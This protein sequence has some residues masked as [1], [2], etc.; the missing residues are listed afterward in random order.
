MKARGTAEIPH[1]AAP[2]SAGEDSDDE[3]SRGGSRLSLD[4]MVPPGRR[5]LNKDSSSLSRAIPASPP[6]PSVP[7]RTST[8]SPPPELPPTGH[9]RPPQK[10]VSRPPPPVPISSPPETS[11]V[12][13]RPP[14]PP[15]PGQPPSRK[16]TSDSRTAPHPSKHQVDNDSEEEVT[17]YDG[18]YD[19][20]IASGAKHKD[21]LK[22][23]D[24][25]SSFD[26]G[27]ITDEATNKSPT[28]PPAR[29]PPPLP[30]SVAPRAIPPAPPGQPPKPNRKSSDMPRAAPPPI[31][32]S[33]ESI[34]NEDYDPFRYTRGVPPP[35]P[36]N[37]RPPIIQSPSNELEEDDM[38]GASPVSS[39]PMPPAPAI[40]RTVPPPAPP[41]ERSVP[42]PPPPPS[43][44]SQPLPGGTN[45]PRKSLD[46]NRSKSTGR[47][48]MEQPRA[49][50]DTGFIASDIDLA[51]KSFWWTQQNLPPQTLQS[52]RDVIFEMDTSPPTQEGSKTIITK[53]I[54]VLYLDYSHT[55]ITASFDQSNPSDVSLEQK[56]QRPPPPPRQD[57]LEN[58]SLHL[59][60]RISEAVTA[61]QNTVVGDGS[62]H[63]LVLE[64]L[65]P[66]ASEA[67][68]P[69][70]NRTYGALVYA[71]LANASTQQYD[72]I[73]AGD[74][75]TFRNAKFQG[76]RGTM[77]QK[78]S[79]EAG[80]PDH[81]GIVLD[82]DGTKKK[83]RAW[84][85]GR[86]NKKVKLE[87]F[88]LGDL[89]SGECRVWRIMGRE[90]VGWDAK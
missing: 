67:L 63:A 74:I 40:E 11:P 82:W 28:S 24:G 83:I 56:H 58:A 38:Y 75:V 22:A 4:Q 90:W 36:P 57:Q 39:P 64:L 31:P 88:K 52:R 2:L 68:M 1:A 65:R 85:Q 47:R 54:Y 66:L 6:V 27:T 3:L 16:S 33:R 41:S 30:P 69:I 55:T 89:R 14:P 80:K 37:T 73:R 26:E 48:S 62:P 77:H 49:S 18:D 44:S 43:Q 15:P 29:G 78:Y 53:D 17:E 7:L 76:H 13:S 72:E 42:L 21:A 50:L 61:A 60:A 87:S 25:D 20:D 45:L 59:G 70:A 35:P 81:V 84:E 8:E 10:R 12:Q 51:E 19:T 34:D 71:N 23:H 79:A 86:E 46:V 9:T 32:P 5:S